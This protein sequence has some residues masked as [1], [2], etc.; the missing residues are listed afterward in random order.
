[1]PLLEEEGSNDNLVEQDS[2]PI[3][4]CRSGLPVALVSKD[5]G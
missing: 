4:T 1:M 3:F 2:L 5:M